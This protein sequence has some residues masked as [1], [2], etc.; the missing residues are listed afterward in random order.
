MADFE[1]KKYSI[2]PGPGRKMDGCPY[3]NFEDGHDVQEY[4]IPPKGYVFSGFRFD[5]DANNQ[6]YDGKLYAQYTK[7]PFNIRLKSNI[8]KLVLAVIIV[9]VIGLII[10]L[11]T[12]VFKDPKPTSNTPKEPK[13]EVATKPSKE[14]EKT[15][16]SL[17]RTTKRKNSRKELR[18]KERKEKRERKEREKQEKL[19]KKEAEK[20]KKEAEKAQKEA[21]KAKKEAEKG[22]KN[23][24]ETTENI[25][26]KQEPE[27]KPQ[28]QVAEQVTQP[29]E[30]VA[31][32]VTDPNVLFKQEF[33]DLVHH[34][35]PS[36]DAYTD[37]YN[38]YKR[39]VKGEEFDYLRYTILKDYVHFKAW[40]DNLKKIPESQL[41]SIE[42]V[43]ALIN[44]INS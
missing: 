42:S 26:Q 11:A 30:P 6:I 2:D 34:R 19:A 9:A 39:D 38:K 33:W 36:M 41:Q 21:E 23:D 13:T 31:P 18:E 15:D 24:K 37:L 8:W 14:L 20:A 22:I 7:E 44:K 35:D 29:Q 16:N 28:E 40:Y 12:S 4:I 5:P 3:S 32:A 1:E 17:S 10:L 43:D 25:Q 27:A